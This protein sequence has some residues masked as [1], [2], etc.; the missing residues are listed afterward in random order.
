MR[1]LRLQIQITVDGFVAGVTNKGMR[2]FEVLYKRQ[3]LSL[4]TATPYECGVTVIRYK[5]INQ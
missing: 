1:K 4:I 5:L 3:I 2:I